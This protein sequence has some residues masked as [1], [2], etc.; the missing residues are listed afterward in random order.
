M[1]QVLKFRSTILPLFAAG[2]L[3]FW[4]NAET[5]A[6]VPAPQKV[7]WR[8]GEV[9]CSRCQISAPAV[10]AF[11]AGE[12]E[13]FLAGAE[14]NSSRTKISL[15]IGPVGSTNLEPY[16]LDAAKDGV[17]ITAPKPAGLFYGVQTLRQLLAGTTKLRCCHVEDWP[18][19]PL[20]GFMHDTGGNFQALDLLK[21]QLYIF[22][23]HKLNVF[24]WHPTDNPA[25][26][27]ECRAFPQL[28]DPKFQ[29]RD[30]GQIYS[31]AQIRGLI[32][33][34]RDGHITIIPELDMPGHSAVFKRVFGFDMSSPQGMDVL[35]KLIADYLT[36]TWFTSANEEPYSDEEFYWTREPAEV[37]LKAGWNKILLRVPCGCAGQNWGIT[38]IPVKFDAGNSRWIED[39]SVRFALGIK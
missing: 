32:A 7:E 30:V 20:R 8:G 27:I 22:A 17:V 25:R 19:V 2:C 35:E 38:F 3:A 39:E 18:A 6:L 29:M 14:K 10:A 31:D 1:D 5:P 34:A 26:R 12:L 11:A 23:A 13:Q 9:D 16:S 36:P 15:R 33:Y 37:S 4:A 21:A 24:H 28:N